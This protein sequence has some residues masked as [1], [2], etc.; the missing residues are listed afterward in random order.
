MARRVMMSSLRGSGGGD[1][2]TE[3]R[4]AA[5]AAA[6]P[7][8]S[9]STQGGK[10][11]GE[12]VPSALVTATSKEKTK[13]KAMAKK[14]GRSRG[15]VIGGM[16]ACESEGAERDER[17]KEGVWVVEDPCSLAQHG[18]S[19]EEP[20][21]MAAQPA[22]HRPG[23]ETEAAEMGSSCLYVMARAEKSAPQCADLE[24]GG[25]RQMT[26]KKIAMEGRKAVVAY[27]PV[28]KA[29]VHS[30]ATGRDGAK[31][32]DRITWENVQGKGEENEEKL[33]RKGGEARREL[34]E[35]PSTPQV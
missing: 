17:E 24:C 20:A 32:D 26:Q 6:I 16:D 3:R 34:S 27:T 15:S 13:G 5:A 35:A 8:L 23:P 33:T 21:E 22:R 1:R 28:K 29:R 7:T 4:T 25:E 19:I 31:G 18:E 9:T 2:R 11:A 14:G 12:V 30:E 10:R